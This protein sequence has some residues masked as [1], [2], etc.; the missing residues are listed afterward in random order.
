[1]RFFTEHPL[2]FVNHR[3]PKETEDH[4]NTAIGSVCAVFEGTPHLWFKGKPKRKTEKSVLGP[5][6]RRKQK[7]QQ[8]KLGLALSGARPTSVGLPNLQPLV[9]DAV[10]GPMASATLALQGGGGGKRLNTK[11]LPQRIL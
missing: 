10:P 3:D 1:M 9:G 11:Y 7:N 4:L 6:T 8:A 5:Q 2:G